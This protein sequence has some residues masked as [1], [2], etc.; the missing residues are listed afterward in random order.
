MFFPIGDTNIVSDKKPFVTY[1]IIALN[2]AIFLY[3]ISLAR[4]GQENIAYQYGCIPV[5][6]FNFNNLYTVFTSMF[7][8]GGWMHLAGNMVFLWVFGDNIEMVIG[9]FSIYAFLYFWRG[10]F[11][12]HSLYLQCLQRSAMHWRIGGNCGV[13]WSLFGNVS[14]F[15]NQNLIYPIFNF[16]QSVCIYFFRNMDIATIYEWPRTNR[17]YY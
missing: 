11:Y 9:R 16:L 7:L 17:C 14:S 15:K 3:Q 10:A 8:H 13:P 5:E 2:I 12:Y 1:F 4:I 6:I